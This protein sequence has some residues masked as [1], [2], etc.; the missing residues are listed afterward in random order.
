VTDENSP[1]ADDEDPDPIIALIPGGGWMI[2]H[3]Q[4]KE[5]RVPGTGWSDPVVAW[6]LCKSGNVIPMEAEANI[7]WPIEVGTEDC[8]FWHPDGSSRRTQNYLR[9]Y[10]EQMEA[11]GG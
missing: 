10:R 11:G 6:A 2:Y 7:V 8:E 4:E 9:Q 1:V 5:Q 3:I